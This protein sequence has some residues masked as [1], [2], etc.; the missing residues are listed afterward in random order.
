[1]AMENFSLIDDSVQFLASGENSSNLSCAV[2]SMEA[3]KE[4]ETNLPSAV[5]TAVRVLQTSFGFAVIFVGAF[6]NSLIL[7]LVYKFKKLRTISFGIVCQIVVAN[8]VVS[9]SFGIPIMINYIAGGWI[10]GVECCVYTGFLINTLGYIRTLLF[11]VFSLDRFFM[12]FAPFAYPKHSLKVVAFLLITVWL[13]CIIFNIT[14]VGLDCFTYKRVLL[15]C[16]VDTSCHQT[17]RIFFYVFYSPT[18]V[19]SILLSVVF[20]V[21]LFVKAK[22]IRKRDENI[23]LSKEILAKQEWR[24]IKTFTILFYCFVLA[25]LLPLFLLYLAEMFSPPVQSAIKLF[26][27]D[28]PAAYVMTDSVL[29]MRNSDVKEALKSLWESCGMYC[30]KAIHRRS[31]NSSDTITKRIEASATSAE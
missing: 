21:A 19:P 30:G 25:T 26:A 17:C 3:G 5:E 15:Y 8:W 1:M 2:L 29:I 31:T 4:I 23:G 7:F 12:V 22:I 6:L 9:V 27:S 10:L 14:L 16:I 24:A 18:I 28:A 20:Y 13:F 11:F